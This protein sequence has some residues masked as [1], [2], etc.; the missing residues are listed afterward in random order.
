[1]RT[2]AEPYTW[3]PSNSQE[4]IDFTLHV[5]SLSDRR[6][7]LTLTDRPP[8]VVLSAQGL[9]LAL[10]IGQPTLE[11]G[12]APSGVVLSAQ[13]L[14][15]SLSIGQP[16]LVVVL[17]AQGL[18][19]SLSIGQPTLVVVAPSEVVLSAQ[20]LNI[21]LSVGRPALVIQPP[22]VVLSAQGLGI[23]LSIGRPALVVAAPAE[24]IL[25]A[26]GLSIAISIGQPTLT[27]GATPSDVVL[28]AQGLS[29]ALAIGQPTL[30]IVDVLPIAPSV[31][32]QSGTVGTSLSVTLNPGTSGNL[33]LSYAVAPLPTGLSFNTNT[34]VISGT[35]LVVGT[36][37]VIYRVIDND[38][39][40]DSSRFDFAIAAGVPSRPATPTIIS[41]GNTDIDVTWVEPNNNGQ[42]SPGIHCAI[43]KLALRVGLGL[44]I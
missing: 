7:T 19:I 24:V 33:P 36:T 11:V 10:A 4:V 39:D 5:V 42:P 44:T 30:F 1:M 32:D 12:P 25:S 43:G 13:G 17:S 37:I 14:D 23:S 27:T 2:P 28:S 22:D 18:D 40:S 38:G 9:S 29:I 21:S 6:A 3:I 26:Q 20:G 8:D 31:A 35:P 15:I 16:T 34:R 41:V